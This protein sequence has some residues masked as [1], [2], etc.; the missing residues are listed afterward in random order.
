M[1]NY[2]R[3]CVVS[4]A[5]A[6]ALSLAGCDSVQKESAQVRRDG[7]AYDKPASDE[8]DD[9]SVD[10]FV[11]VEAHFEPD[12]GYDEPGFVI[13]AMNNT[14]EQ[15]KLQ[16][17]ALSELDSDG[18]ILESYMSYNQNA[19]EAVVMPGQQVSIPLISLSGDEISGVQCTGYAY[20]EFEDMTEGT[21]SEVFIKKF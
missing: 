15:K 12:G 13:T 19:V 21:F 14:N 7:S 5:G 2:S 18:N 20:G 4:A 17:I 3:R 6:I 1:K 11:M 10:E 9:G 8:T 16:G